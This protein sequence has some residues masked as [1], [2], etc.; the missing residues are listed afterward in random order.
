MDWT[1]LIAELGRLGYTQPKIAEECQC[2]QATISDLA[3]GKSKEPR[4]ALGE[5]LKA[6]LERAKSEKARA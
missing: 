6:L 4:H 3:N 2:G 5:E 1:S